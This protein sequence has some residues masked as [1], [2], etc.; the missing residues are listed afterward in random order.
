MPSSTATDDIRRLVDTICNDTERT[1]QGMAAAR[2][3]MERSSASVQNA[4]STLSSI[5]VQ[6]EASQLATDEIS[7]AMNQQQTASQQVAANVEMIARAALAC[8]GR[9]PALKSTNTR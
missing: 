6:S 2:A 1:A 3:G 5:R 4:S 8:R 9:Q 7:V